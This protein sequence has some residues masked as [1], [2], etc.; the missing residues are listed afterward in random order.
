MNN[1]R[2][3]FCTLREKK[4]INC[5]KLIIVTAHTEKCINAVEFLF[6]IIKIRTLQML[7]RI[8]DVLP[9]TTFVLLIPTQYSIMV[10]LS[11]NT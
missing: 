9:C 6:S 4:K 3:S 5:F 11:W 2:R 8:I 10:E 1:L 7:R